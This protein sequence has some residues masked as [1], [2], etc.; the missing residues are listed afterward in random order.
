MTA[1]KYSA[2]WVSHSSMA[3]FLRCPRLYYLRNVY[4]DPLTGHKITRME[5]PLALGQVVHDVVES[6][7]TLH[8]EDRLKISLIKKF[9]AEWEKVTGKKGGFA[10]HAQEEEY[11]NRGREMLMRVMEN[12]GPIT[13]KAIKIKEELPYYW[14]SED[15]NII[16]CGK[17][18]WLEYLPETDSV[19]IIDFK[20]G[21]REEKEDSLQLPVYQLLVTN[22]QSKRLSKASYWYLLTSDAPKEVSLPSLEESQERVMAVAKRMKLARQISHFKCADGGCRYCTPLEEVVK[23]KGELVG[24]SSYNQDIYII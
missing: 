3:D 4:K 21:K 19:H 8:A 16:L 18:D 15:E 12:P 20:T 17:I 13:Q 9:D 23:G 6:L 22:T 14:L 2:V 24:T 10:D 1:D 7:S 11:K 5:P